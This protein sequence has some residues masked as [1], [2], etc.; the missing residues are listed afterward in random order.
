MKLTFIL[1]FILLGINAAAQ[2][3]SPADYALTKFTIKDKKLGMISFYVDTVNIDKRPLFFDINGS[4]GFPLCLYIESKNGSTVSNT[5]NPKLIEKVKKEYH[6][7]ILDKPGT[8]FCDTIQTDKLIKDLDITSV[9]KNYKASEEYTKRLSLEWRVES[10]QKVITFMTKRGYWDKSKII[11][12]GYS[13][14]GQVVPKLAAT[15]N[16]ITHVISVV[17][18]GLNQFYDDALAWRLKAA[19]GYLTQNQ[20]QDSLNLYFDKIKEI[21]KQPNEVNKEYQGHS[22]KRWASFCSTISF[23]ELRKLNIPIS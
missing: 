16:R 6:Y 1:A 18:S 4:G 7:I 15:D 11:V 12:Y 13:E 14:G 22:Y 2:P 9:M 8:P 21:Y 10:I 5:F 20:A 23:E 17:G 19:A 3:V